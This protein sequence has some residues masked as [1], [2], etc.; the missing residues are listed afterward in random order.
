MSESQERDLK[1]KPKTKQR[2][3][4]IHAMIIYE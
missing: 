1:D 2:K 3:F 4:E